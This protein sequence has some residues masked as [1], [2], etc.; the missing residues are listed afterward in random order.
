[1]CF[2]SAVATRPSRG[3]SNNSVIGDECYPMITGPQY[4]AAKLR[5]AIGRNAYRVRVW[6]V[7]RPEPTGGSGEFFFRAFCRRRWGAM[8]Q[9][10]LHVMRALSLFRLARDQQV[11]L[12]TLNQREISQLYRLQREDLL[13]LF[14]PLNPQSPSLTPPPRF[15]S[16]S[17][18]PQVRIL[19]CLLKRCSPEL[20]PPL[21][22]RSVGLLSLL[23]PFAWAP[24]L[25]LAPSPPMPPLRL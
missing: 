10:P 23:L 25:P 17:F 21:A 16:T 8:P 18:S 11:K 22:W 3:G 24:S 15:S 4:I 5:R 7:W 1:M 13:Y 9:I 6:P 14:S 19:T 12:S 20:F 2:I